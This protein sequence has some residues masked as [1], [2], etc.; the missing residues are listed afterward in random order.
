MHPVNEIGHKPVR[1]LIVD[2][3]KRYGGA[4]TRAVALARALRDWDVA[5]AALDRS[6]V[7]VAA[8]EAG[9]PVITIAGQKWDPRI[10]FRLA[11]ACR[12]GYELLDTQNIQAKVWSS[13]AALLSGAV[14]VSTLNSW[15]AAEHDG[16]VKG[17]AYAALERLTGFR[18]D[19]YIAVSNGIR[20]ALCEAD[21][22]ADAIEVIH[23]GIGA[24]PAAGP[25]AGMVRAS[26]GVPEGA[27]LCSAVGR[28]VWA[29]GYGDLINAFALVAEGMPSLHGVIVGEGELRADLERRIVKAGLSTRLVLAGFRSNEDVLR[30]LQ[31]SDVFLMPSRTEGI[32]YALLEAGAL[33]LPIVASRCGGI[34]E[35]VTNGVD[36][37]LVEPGDV[38]G[39]AAGLESLCRDQ[40]RAKQ[41]GRNAKA[42]IERDFSVEAQAAAIKAAYVRAS[43]RRSRV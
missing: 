18:T 15:Y 34:P 3:S 6:P 17:T 9:V 28:L 7:A 31:A 41:L 30:I 23:N 25:D 43:Q 19:R 29:K 36:A 40:P 39:I 10:P 5:I 22:P 38:H 32:P 26:L 33:G 24:M 11:A 1:A 8:R 14:L 21:F 4:S 27:L 12:G 13:I 16:T 2:L 42:R 35:V 37:L 20:Q